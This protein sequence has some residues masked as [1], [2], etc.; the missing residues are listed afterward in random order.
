MWIP[1]VK[2]HG[3]YRSLAIRGRPTTFPL[4]HYLIRIQN[5]QH[6]AAN[7]REEKEEKDNAEN[8][9]RHLDR[10]DERHDGEERQ[11]TQDQRRNRGGG[12]LG[13]Q[14]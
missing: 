10:N 5:M 11:Q 9:N 12:S 2:T 4:T 1:W 3:Y 14:R 7:Q 13:Q 6:R 8:E